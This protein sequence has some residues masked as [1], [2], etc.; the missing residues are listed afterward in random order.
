MTAMAEDF[1]LGTAL[2]TNGGQPSASS[3]G[4]QGVRPG[5]EFLNE[6]ERVNVILAPFQF[7]FLCGKTC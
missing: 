4:G 5:P 7:F 2:C 1:C 3:S 6:G